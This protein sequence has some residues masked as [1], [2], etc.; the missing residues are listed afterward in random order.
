[1]KKGG[2]GGANTTTGAKFEKKAS[3]DD[4]LKQRED[5]DV[6]NGKIYQNEKLIGYIYQKTAF[7]AFLKSNG[8]EMTDIL[9]KRLEPDNALFNLKNNTLY[10]IEIKYQETTGSTDEKLQT[11]DF[12]RQQY[13]KLM[14]ELK[15]VMGGKYF[16]V[17][18]VYLLNDWFE[19]E[20]YKDSLAYILGQG[21]H[22]YFYKDFEGFLNFLEL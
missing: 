17:E 21:C 11:C 8:V 7:G 22:Y 20:G 10:I 14:K 5:V 2:T 1:M 15:R 18:Y 13:I 4:I 6:K 3:L 12:K 9:S 16:K 19:K